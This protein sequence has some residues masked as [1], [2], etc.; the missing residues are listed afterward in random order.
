MFTK[1]SARRG[2][3]KDGETEV[4]SREIVIPFAIRAFSAAKPAPRS[5]QAGCPF[6][7]GQEAKQE[8]QNNGAF[9]GKHCWGSIRYATPYSI[10][11]SRAYPKSATYLFV[12]RCARRNR[13]LMDKVADGS[14]KCCPNGLSATILSLNPSSCTHS[15]S[16]KMRECPSFH[17]FHGYCQLYRL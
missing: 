1:V 12:D 8:F 3:F 4:P 11:Q 13:K 5:D 7:N 14:A 2:I 9:V 10:K 15:N 6:N 17:T 16:K